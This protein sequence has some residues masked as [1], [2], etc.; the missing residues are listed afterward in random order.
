MAVFTVSVPCEGET[1]T[2][3]LEFPVDITKENI[4]LFFYRL[5]GFFELAKCSMASI[6]STEPAS[7]D[8]E[9]EAY[10]QEHGCI[11]PE[12]EQ[13]LALTKG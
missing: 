6:M 10:F 5:S 11:M 12:D 4:D 8:P 1:V 13:R 3:E 7:S 2:R 9:R